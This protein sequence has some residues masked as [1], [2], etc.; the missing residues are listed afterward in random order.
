MKQ[1]L[2]QEQHGT[3]HFDSG[4]SDMYM[5]IQPTL[6][7]LFTLLIHATKCIATGGGHSEQLTVTQAV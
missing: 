7:Q 5:T 1:R 2:I 6:R 3:V 4:D